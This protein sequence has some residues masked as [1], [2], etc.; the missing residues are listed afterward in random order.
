MLTVAVVISGYLY[1]LIDLGQTQ[2]GASDLT[3]LMKKNHP[4]GI[5]YLNE[6]IFF[7]VSI[8]LLSSVVLIGLYLILP[9][10]TIIAQQ[11]LVF[12]LTW[13]GLLGSAVCPPWMAI[14]LNDIK[15]YAYA[16][17][18]PK[19][20]VII[21]TILVNYFYKIETAS[22]IALIYTASN[23]IISL[24]ISREF[25]YNSKRIQL[26]A[27]SNKRKV[28]NR[29]KINIKKSY[30]S[31]ASSSYTSVLIFIASNF[32]SYVQV[33][34]FAIADKICRSIL[35]IIM[36][37]Y[38]MDSTKLEYKQ[39][40]KK[41]D[42]EIISKSFLKCIIG[43]IIYYTAVTIIG[44]EIIYLLFESLK[45]KLIYDSVKMLLPIVVVV[46]ISG[47]ILVFKLI[48]WKK[49]KNALSP[50]LIGGVAGIMYFIIIG[51]NQSYSLEISSVIAE[52]T[53]LLMLIY[54]V[55][56]K[57]VKLQNM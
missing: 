15:F 47:W 7:K 10:K 52:L 55:R 9:E 44:K 5:K 18:G 35:D 3:R 31:L 34:T 50:Y 19:M 56:F 22:E 54:V 42:T 14:A 23:L 53:V 16:S 51:K 30:V 6:S 29:A 4:V 38:Q 49:Y 32:G 12:I 13:I 28:F 1:T 36:L 2:I 45:A 40:R 21:V 33:A 48:A 43:S 39:T 46:A 17:I 26:D 37:K 25:L 8:I 20:L 57:N 27:I 24:L 11:L 41:N